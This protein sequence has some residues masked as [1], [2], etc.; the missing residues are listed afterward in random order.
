MSFVDKELQCSECGATFTFD[1]A[2]QETFAS[3]GYTN[4]PRR[5]PSCREARRARN[6]NS[7]GFSSYTP[8]RQMFPVVCAQCGKDTEVPFEPRNDRPVYCRDCYNKVA[9]K[10]Y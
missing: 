4:E 10:R 1:V 5:C 7:D 9:P 8:R 2:E 6:P 3:R